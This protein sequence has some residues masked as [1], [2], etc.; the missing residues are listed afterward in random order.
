MRFLILL[1]LLTSC[2]HSDGQLYFGRIAGSGSVDPAPSNPDSVLFYDEFNG[3]SLSTGYYKRRPD[4]STF[5]VS[6]GKLSVVGNHDTYVPPRVG[7]NGGYKNY[8][9][10]V[11]DT[12]YGASMIRDYKIRM[13]FQLKEVADS[14][15]RGVWIGG[16]SDFLF[17]EYNFTTGVYWDFR[18]DSLMVLGSTDST[19][20]VTPASSSVAALSSAFHGNL[21]DWWELS[22]ECREYGGIGKLVNL[23][24]GDTT[25]RTAYWY[26]LGMLTPQRPNYF[27]WSF[28]AVNKTEID[29]DYIKVTT[30][31]LRNRDIAFVGNSITSGSFGG[32]YDS[33]FAKILATKTTLT[34]QIWAGGG[35]DVINI[36]GSLPELLW[37]NPGH[38]ILC[39]GTNNTYSTPNAAYYS[40]FVDSLDAH[41]ITSTK[42]LI[43]NGGDP[44][45]G[46]G[47]NKW[48]KDTYA[49]TYLDNWTTGW[50]TMSTGNGEM[51]DAV[52]PSNT[53]MRKQANII[54]AALIAFFP[55]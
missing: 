45:S 33:S 40:R 36:F 29:I 35:Q 7:F 5:T 27:H 31:Q 16:R 50:N 20:Y 44:V 1:I 30:N 21:T 46:S 12:S 2:I 10:R 37:L 49:S 19:Y 9:T 11:W 34:T 22:F 41:G 13:K 28:A 26:W 23:T 6:G 38:V 42:L 25:S 52:H 4:L 8:M 47:W 48:I 14:G 24:T 55:L 39:L 43:P 15:A 53:G 17:G 18:N 51:T 3:S 32:H 54:K